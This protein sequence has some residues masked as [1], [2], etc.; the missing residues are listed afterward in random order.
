MSISGSGTR[1]SSEHSQAIGSLATSTTAATYASS[2]E[3][4]ANFADYGDFLDFDDSLADNSTLAAILVKQT[5]YFCAPGEG[6]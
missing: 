6:F 2:G 3:I 4:A 5:T 1:Q